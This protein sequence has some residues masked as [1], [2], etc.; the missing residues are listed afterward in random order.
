[1]FGCLKCVAQSFL[2][3]MPQSYFSYRML[4]LLACTCA[5][6][7][8]MLLSRLEFSLQSPIL[9]DFWLLLLKRSQMLLEMKYFTVL[10]EFFKS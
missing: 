6:W 8:G 10:L 4:K 3:S 5:S 7:R 1:M 2:T 9:L